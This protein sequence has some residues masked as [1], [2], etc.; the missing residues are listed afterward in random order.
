MTKKERRRAELDAIKILR[1]REAGR[2]TDEAIKMAIPMIN[3]RPTEYTRTRRR[4]ALRAVEE[5]KR[6]K[7][8]ADDYEKA[9]QVLKP[10]K[11]PM[12]EEQKTRRRLERMQGKRATRKQLDAI[13]AGYSAREI[14]HKVE[15]DSV[16]YKRRAYALNRRYTAQVSEYV[17]AWGRETLNEELEYRTAE[18][19]AK[20]QGW[21]R[22]DQVDDSLGWAIFSGLDKE[23]QIITW[24]RL[25][26]AFPYVRDAE[27]EDA[28]KKYH[29]SG[30]FI[31]NNSAWDGFMIYGMNK[32]QFESHQAAGDKLIPKLFGSEYIYKEDFD[33]FGIVTT[34]KEWE[35]VEELA[36][37]W[38]ISRKYRPKRDSYVK[39]READTWEDDRAGMIKK[40]QEELERVRKHED[41]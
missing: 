34:R 12:T 1:L 22:E 31:Y 25:T 40:A 33:G 14:F 11:K 38:S 36:D 19:I 18:Q 27:L 4:R 2:G 28:K 10:R 3:S 9:K 29:S 6:L 37:D 15:R 30:F 26:A 13:K 17:E 21:E 41:N 32:G 7:M 16:T 20:R 24:Q 35:N 8:Y 39:Y 5:A 23:T